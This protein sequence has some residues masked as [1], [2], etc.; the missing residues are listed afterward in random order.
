MLTNLA[1]PLSICDMN[2]STV[3]ECG[4][5]VQLQVRLRDRAV[6]EAVCRRR[7]WEFCTGQPRRRWFGRA[8]ADM[9]LSPIRTPYSHTIGIPGC[10]DEI[11]LVQQPTHYVLSWDNGVD[12]GLE[13]ALGP[14]LRKLWWAYVV[15]K[16]QREA[17]RVGHLV[18][19][20][21]EL[22]TTLRLRISAVGVCAHL[23]LTAADRATFWSI[24][25]QAADTFRYL[26]D[27]LGCIESPSTPDGESH[28]LAS[29]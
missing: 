1:K 12:G 15:A 24:G 28:D 19:L 17:M 6:L 21:L 2:K 4:D 18:G 27:A 5:F 11:G 23:C 3:L 8:L 14:G 7:G 29:S 9:P 16:A 10:L 13:A 20:P 22:G 25:P 26:I